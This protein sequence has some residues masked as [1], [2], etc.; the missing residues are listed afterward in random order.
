MKDYQE[1]G[2]QVFTAEEVNEVGAK[3]SENATMVNVETLLEAFLEDFQTWKSLLNCWRIKISR[4]SA[5]ELKKLYCTPK[6]T[7]VLLVARKDVN[8]EKM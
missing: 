2:D 4:V 6:N 5:S 1:T 7:E 8:L 3:G